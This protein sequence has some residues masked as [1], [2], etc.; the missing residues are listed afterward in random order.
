MIV[1]AK[2]GRSDRTSST[3]SFTDNHRVLA[4]NRHFYAGGY[5]VKRGDEPIIIRRGDGVAA[6]ESY[7][8]DPG[9][10][11]VL[12]SEREGD[13]R[14]MVRENE[15]RI[16]VV[17]GARGVYAAETCRGRHIGT[18]NTLRDA[19]LLLLIAKTKA[20]G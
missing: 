16:G 4:T 6:V 14:Y 15:I 12:K 19:I 2:D 1:S 8:N 13:A 7:T 11:S 5:L 3:D 20:H 18:A 9:E 17:L 10:F